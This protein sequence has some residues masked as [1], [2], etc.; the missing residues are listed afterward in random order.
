M[1]ASRLDQHIVNELVKQYG[2]NLR[3]IS[4]LAAGKN[5]DSPEYLEAARPLLQVGSPLV[6]VAADEIKSYIFFAMLKVI[7]KA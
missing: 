2:D 4:Q 1:D 6:G 5:L 3:K 7:G